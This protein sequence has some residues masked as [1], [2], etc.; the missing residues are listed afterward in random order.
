MEPS[1]KQTQEDTESIESPVVNLGKRTRSSK[2]DEEE[3]EPELQKMVK[4]EDGT[5]KIK[6][7]NSGA[8]Q[9]M[10]ATTIEKAN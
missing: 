10:L 8:I 2:V 4:K 9:L 5:P 7:T 6:A 1:T 3:K